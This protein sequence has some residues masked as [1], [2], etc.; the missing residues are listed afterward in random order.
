VIVFV[1]VS[2]PAGASIGAIDTTTTT[3]TYS[4]T[5]STATDSSTVIAGDLRLVKTQA[6]DA[7]CDGTPDGSFSQADAAALP[8][9]CVVYQITATNQGTADVTSIVIS[10]STP[11]YTVYFEP[12]VGS[13]ASSSIAGGTITKPVSGNAGT[14]SVNLGAASLAPGASEVF[15]FTVKINP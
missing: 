15:T 1:K 6:L 13:A 4:A 11:A 8:G 14:V 3:A 7:A 2:A 9:Q 10:D 12:T 5:T